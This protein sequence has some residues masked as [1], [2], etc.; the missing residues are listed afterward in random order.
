ML[1]ELDRHLLCDVFALH[2][3]VVSYCRLCTFI[4]GLSIYPKEEPTNY[5]VFSY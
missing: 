2:N 4:I 1:F 3:A 5:V